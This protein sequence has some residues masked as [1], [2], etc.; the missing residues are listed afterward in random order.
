MLALGATLALPSC[1]NEP[2]QEPAVLPSDVN[3]PVSTWYLTYPNGHPLAAVPADA[4]Q[5]G[6]EQALI[7]AINQDRQQAGVA[8]LTVLTPLGDVARAFSI[9]SVLGGFSG[10]TDPEGDDPA[11]RA[12]RANVSVTEID[13][14]LADG[15]EYP[16]ADSV[17]TAWLAD[18]A[19]KAKL[20]DPKWT[21][22]GAGFHDSPVDYTPHWTLDLAQQAP[23][24]Q[25][26]G[27]SLPDPRTRDR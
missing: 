26:A 7:D 17:M 13:E 25:D 5:S 20:E 18:P 4:F 21:V 2:P 11:G 12:A 14:S 1:G 6:Q 9:H 16:T 23:A 24:S 8:P 27:T 10:D 3:S 15:L 19:M 22:I